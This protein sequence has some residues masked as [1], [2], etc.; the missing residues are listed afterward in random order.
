MLDYFSLKTL[1]AC[2]KIPERGYAVLDQPQ[3]TS[4]FRRIEELAACCGWSSIQPRSFFRQAPRHYSETRK[5]STSSAL[6]L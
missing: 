1:R 2:L 3:Q 4:N 5:K 6:R